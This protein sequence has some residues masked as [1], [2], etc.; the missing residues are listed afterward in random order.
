[1]G[2]REVKVPAEG[3]PD[4]DLL[5][6]SDPLPAEWVG[7]DAIDPVLVARFDRDDLELVLATGHSLPLLR[8]L[9]LAPDLAK[10]RLEKLVGPFCSSKGTCSLFDRTDCRTR[11]PKLMSCFRATNPILTELARAFDRGLYV[12]R[13]VV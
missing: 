10:I 4:L 5:L 3:G 8:S 9:G 13:V 1:M 11:A 2:A 12:V 6:L 7:V